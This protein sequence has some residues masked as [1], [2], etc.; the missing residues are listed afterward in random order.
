MVRGRGELRIPSTVKQFIM[1]RGHRAGAEE[2]A[3]HLRALPVL[4]EVLASIPSTHMTIH[5][6]L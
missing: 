6:H 2:L 1:V 4:V 3:Q 5:H